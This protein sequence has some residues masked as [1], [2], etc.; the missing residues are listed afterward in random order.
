MVFKVKFFSSKKSSETSS[1]DGSNNSPRSFNSNSSSP[2]GSDKN[3][4]KSKSVS[5]D[6]MYNSSSPSSKNT[7]LKQVKQDKVKSKDVISSKFDS[8][9]GKIGRSSGKVKST[10]VSCLNSNLLPTE[11]SKSKK[12]EEGLSTVSPI[13]ASS[14]GLNR[15]KTRSGPLPQERF[16]GD[17]SGSFGKGVTGVSNLSKGGVE[18][19]GGGKG[20]L[21]KG[22]QRKKDLENVSFVGWA[23]NRSVGDGVVTESAERDQSPRV[24]VRSGFQNAE[25]SSSDA[26]TL[27]ITLLMLQFDARY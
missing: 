24:Q 16:F 12:G 27:T 3:K 8:S 7:S 4:V 14:L 10:P 9:S 13:L 15:I 6:D 20:G 2:S 17:N 21:K 11:L 1:P 18:G 5:I 25:A 19:L 23:D 26:G 22:D